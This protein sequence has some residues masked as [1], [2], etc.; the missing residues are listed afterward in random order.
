M[1]KEEKKKQLIEAWKSGNTVVVAELLL[2]NPDLC[3]EFDFIETIKIP[4]H[5][6]YKT[7]LFLLPSSI[8]FGLI[9]RA[10]YYYLVQI[11]Q[12]YENVFILIFMLVL[13]GILLPVVFSSLVSLNP[14]NIKSPAFPLFLP[15]LS[16]IF[17]ISIDNIRMGTYDSSS[18]I[19][20]L[21]FG[22][23]S[24]FILGSPARW[25]TKRI[26]GVARCDEPAKISLKVKCATDVLINAL[27]HIL[28]LHFFSLVKPEKLPQIHEHGL[29]K[30]KARKA[31][32]IYTFTLKIR[33]LEMT[34]ECGL[35][36]FLY[37]ED[38]D[39]IIADDFCKELMEEIIEDLEKKLKEVEP[40]QMGEFSELYNYALGSTR[41]KIQPF[42]DNLKR[43]FAR[44][45][46]VV[47][48]GILIGIALLYL[49]AM[50][51]NVVS[52]FKDLLSVIGS[53]LTIASIIGGW[54]WKR[55]K[56]PRQT[57]KMN[58]GRKRFSG[59]FSMVTRKRSGL[60]KFFMSSPV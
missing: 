55:R 17:A 7:F 25:L 23:F 6:K 2:K 46:K 41:S 49:A 60:N 3:E 44:V 13:I 40:W 24:T 52:Q 54:L 11:M 26:V 53:M 59:L 27:G 47:Y 1:S 48:A 37:Q 22:M 4:F 18:L 50:N 31:G 10:C 58:K 9:W 35:S 8:V 5:R 32:K 56:K 12:G 21:I 30:F 57:E 20:V 29:A 33:S 38:D 45:P 34:D 42:V 36:A 16:V 43:L 51:L 28:E 15:G 14:L 19:V 39:G